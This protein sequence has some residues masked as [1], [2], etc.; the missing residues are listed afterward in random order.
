MLKDINLGPDSS[1]PQSFTVAGNVVFFGA[2]DGVRYG[3]WKTDGTKDN[4]ILV[5]PGF[6][7]AL[8]LIG[9][10]LMFAGNDGTN[11]VELWK[12]D[13]TPSGTGMLTDIN[14]G[15]NSS[16][17]GLSEG[18]VVNGILI[19]AAD[20]GVYGEQPWRSDGTRQGTFLLKDINPGSGA[21]YPHYFTVASGFVFFFAQ[22]ALWRTDGSPNGTVLV[23]DFSTNSAYGYLNELVNANG[24][25]FFVADDGAHGAELWKSGGSSADTT[26]VKDIN[27]GANPSFPQ[28]LTVVGTN[29]FFAADD[30]VHGQ[31]LWRSDG[32][33]D[34]TVMILINPSGDAGISGLVNV[35]GTLFFSADDGVHGLELW[36]SDGTASG[37]VMVQDLNPGVDGSNPNSLTASDGTLFFAATD[38]LH[39]G[40]LYSLVPEYTIGQQIPPAAPVDLS[41]TPQGPIMNPS[42]AVCW[43][44]PSGPAFAQVPGF[45]SLIWS[46]RVTLAGIQT[47]VAVRQS[48]IIRDIPPAQYLL[49][50]EIRP[51]DGASVTN[52]PTVSPSD[53]A[54]WHA[55]THKLYATGLYTNYDINWSGT[56][57][58]G[59]HVLAR[60]VWDPNASYQ[61]HIANTPPVPLTAWGVGSQA[62][63]LAT[64]SST[65]AK[66]NPISGSISAFSATGPGRS[67]V[68][69][70]PGN[71]AS[72]NIYFQLVKTIAWNDPAYLD[73]NGVAIIGQGI[74]DTH[75]YHDASLGSPWVLDPLSRYCDWTNYYDR[76]SRTGPIIP[77]NENDPSANDQLVLICYQKGAALFDPVSSNLVSSS[78]AWPYQAVQYDCQWPT[79]AETIVIAS[80]LGT[81]PIDPHIYQNWTI[82]VQNDPT[83]PGFNPND[84]HAMS[85]GPVI[86]ALRDDLGTRTTS[87]PYVLMTYQ[88]GTDGNKPKLRV[89]KV[90]AG[91][92]EYSAVAGKPVLPPNPLT[93]Q[94]PCQE[95]YGYAGPYW[96]DRSLGFWA[97]AA[98]DHGGPT[99][100]TMRYWY[101]VQAGFYF[102]SEY[103]ANFPPGVA[104]TNL[105][106]VTTHFPWLDIRGG[107]PGTPI[108]VNF[109]VNWPTNVAQLSIGETLFT[110]KPAAGG[111]SLP[112]IAGNGT[113]VAILYEQAMATGGVHSVQLILPTNAVSV[114]LSDLPQNIQPPPITNLDYTVTFPGLP[115]DLRQR[116]WW[117]GKL[118]RLV[119]EG[120]WVTNNLHRVAEPLGYLLLNVLTPRDKTNLLAVATNSTPADLDF[121]NAVNALARSAGQAMLPGGTNESPYDSLALSAGNALAGGFVTLAMNDNPGTLPDVEVIRVGCP[122]YVGDVESIQSPNPFDVKQ[123]LQYSGDFGGNAGNY[124]FEWQRTLS[125]AG[126]PVTNGWT[127]VAI[128]PGLVNFT[129][130]GAGPDVLVDHF[131]RCRYQP[132]TNALCGPGWSAWSDGNTLAP[133]WIGNILSKINLFDQRFSDYTNNQVDTVISALTQAGPRWIGNVPLTSD[134]SDLGL[135]QIY[136]TILKVGEQMSID[137]PTYNSSD[138][139]LST[140]VDTALMDAA[141]RLADLY[142]LF[143]N[144]AYAEATDPTVSF[145][146]QTTTY[147]TTASSIFSFEGDPN[148]PTLL[149]QELALLRGRDDSYLPPVETYPVYNRLYW[150]ISPGG[151]QD[152]EVA[153][154]NT[155][156]GGDPA[157]APSYFPQGHGDAWGHYLTA[158]TEYYGLFRNPNFTMIPALDVEAVL[159]GGVTVDEGLMHE[160]KFATA[161]AARAQTGLDIINLTYRSRYQETANNQWEGYYDS[162]TN[163]AWGVSE[164]GM[165]A[166]L[167]AYFDWVT[168]N[169]I[170]PHQDTNAADIGTIAQVDRTT[171]TELSQIASTAGDIQSQLDNADQG[172]NPLGVPKDIV[173]MDIDPTQVSQGV[174]QFTQVYNK[175]VAAMNNLL[176]VFNYAEASTAALRQQADTVQQFQNTVA[177]Q[178]A[179]YNNQLITIFGTPYPQ[180]PNYPPGYNGPDINNLD[181]NYID[182]QP[183]TGVPPPTTGT[184]THYFYTSSTLPNGAVVLT[185]NAVVLTLA[186]DGLQFVKPAAWT[187]PRVSPGTIQQALGNLLQAH[188]KFNTALLQYND[189]INQIQD[190]SDLLESQYGVNAG[191]INILNNGLSTQ[192]TLDQQIYQDQQNVFNYSAAA[193]QA[194]AVGNAMATMLPLSA[195]LSDDVTSAIR[196]AIQLDAALQAAALGSQGNQSSLAELQAQQDAQLNQAANNIAVTLNQQVQGITNQIIQLQQLVQQEPVQ[197]SQLDNL[198]EAI[199]EA[200]ENYRST[201]GPRRAGAG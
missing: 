42:G 85:D 160:R 144:E 127:D 107:T 88:D 116:I 163:R 181:F 49:G 10:N 180:D 145:G 94:P 9:T 136:E 32:S 82:Y 117:D 95:T 183:I 34:G 46:N 93:T 172:L 91:A 186:D 7:Q 146:D 123:T 53:A 55:P 56:G 41:L 164:W 165:K 155:Y 142:M 8:G 47:A 175:A 151:N 58:A 112:A 37:T 166:G 158:L 12:S 18:T 73:T 196:G 38:G 161:A 109:T 191:Q 188:Q 184:V 192:T 83:Q 147:A 50:Q 31:Q 70:S 44:T 140:A 120:L 52:G 143:G 90:E 190:Q 119:F 149:Y 21:S 99:N 153:Y 106:P 84:E 15:A 54:Y 132:L 124:N 64:D 189:L 135:I 89:F 114:P 179:S 193:S 69:E 104:P 33:Q 57:C 77:V 29:L 68:M 199:T 1:N 157:N 63:L 98:G 13:G 195:G 115:P 187:Q 78:I 152:G 62:Q 96:Q 131:F 169:A 110:E 66:V 71:P 128:G 194:S 113:N 162:N 185:T 14:S 126:Q 154:V 178:E 65:G 67:L 4:T 43:S 25:L 167:A 121:K 19:F 129:I 79:N 139:A 130:E 150:N 137:N 133:G 97:R 125:N 35:N 87:Q 105:P 159:V 100:I 48:F 122:G 111:G 156:C 171:V 3:L 6:V 141:G 74:T 30:G 197:R 182:Y 148:A 59:I 22:S 200:A 103:F 108:D 170:L 86:F 174:S 138:P 2:N 92:F 198:Q 39:G 81:G 20:D 102:P 40:Q 75:G 72:T 168:A 76:A 80:G 11:G 101:P 5:A 17:S 24:T 118:N 16:L 173:P 51:P 45:A 61:T 134:A 36:K 201:L 176:A 26:I 60:N 23:K 177:N 27:P 28:Q